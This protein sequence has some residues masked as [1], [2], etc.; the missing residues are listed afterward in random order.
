MR[1][2]QLSPQYSP[3]AAPALASFESGGTITPTAAPSGATATF[4]TTDTRAFDGV[5][6]IKSINPDKATDFQWNL[7][8]GLQYTADRNGV[9]FVSIRVQ[10]TKEGQKLDLY[11]QK[12]GTDSVLL[13]CVATSDIIGTWVDFGQLIDL[14]AAQVMNV[15]FIHRGVSVNDTMPIFI[16]AFSINNRDRQILDSF[17]AY[18]PPA[19]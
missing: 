14:N 1:L 4:E 3:N 7:G 15:R 17:P 13:E 8:T 19:P 12:G 18:T 10:F 9:R 16:D 11:L 2:T 6:F 5:R